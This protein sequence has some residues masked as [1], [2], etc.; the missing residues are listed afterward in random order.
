MSTPNSASDAR[1]SY[2]L[3]DRLKGRTLLSDQITLYTDEPTGRELGGSEAR[4]KRI[5][6]IE[7][8]DTPRRWGVLGKIQ[9]LEADNAEGGH[10]EELAELRDRADALRAK[11][12]ETSFTFHLQ[13]LSDDEHDGIPAVET[14][15]RAHLLLDPEGEIPEESRDAYSARFA[16]EL[17]ARVV[18][19]VTDAQGTPAVKLTADD[20]SQLPKGFLP[21]SEFRRLQRKV[22][23]LQYST[24][25][26][27]DAVDDV[28]F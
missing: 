8:P 1:S 13:A 28:D 5:A 9:E 27:E 20:V 17:L 21:R 10:D 26:A 3:L 4:V 2:S 24:A 19:T 18:V 15:V 7:V 25:I 11:L 6:G 23:E 14:A 16:A 22:S 12:A